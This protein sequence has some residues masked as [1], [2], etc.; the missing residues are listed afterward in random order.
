M[1]RSAVILGVIGVVL[2]I[3]VGRII[4]VARPLG[5]ICI[6]IAFVIFLA[7]RQ[8]AGS[9]RQAKAEDEL[10]AQGYKYFAAAPD[11]SAIGLDAERQQILLQNANKQSKK[12]PFTAIRSWHVNYQS[13]GKVEFVPGGNFSQQM[14]TMGIQHRANKEAAR[15][16]RASNGLFIRVKDIDSPE[17]HIGLPSQAE[18]SR[19]HEILTQYLNEG[20]GEDASAA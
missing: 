20:A 14:A 13:T 4:W 16:D 5:A 8:S 1:K 11:G 10:R 2:F 3:L 9:K 19:W 18:Q 12:Y 7:T 15:I 17:W 6:V